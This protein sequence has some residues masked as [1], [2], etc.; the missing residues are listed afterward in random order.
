[1]LYMH[2]A[3]LECAS[4]K[5]LAGFYRYILLTSF[6]YRQYVLSLHFLRVK[7]RE[8]DAKHVGRQRILNEIEKRFAKDVA[9]GIA[10]RFRDVL[11]YQQIQHK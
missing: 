1:M 5:K 6:S 11:E 7:S 10:K 3:C 9:A 8:P 2:F 4:Y